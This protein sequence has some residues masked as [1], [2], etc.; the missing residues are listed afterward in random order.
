MSLRKRRQNLKLFKALLEIIK[1]MPIFRKSICT[2]IEEENITKK[3][4][5]EIIG[6]PKF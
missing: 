1:D 2:S 6:F 4:N 5:I 3:H